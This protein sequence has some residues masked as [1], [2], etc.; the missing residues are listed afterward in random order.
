MELLQ[1]S[2]GDA[3][4]GITLEKIYQEHRRLVLKIC[5]GI[6]HDKESAEDAFQ[7]PFLKVA[8]N[9]QELNKNPELIRAKNNLNSKKHCL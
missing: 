1:N 7:S 9:I 6:L 3:S 2:P 8:Q 5:I 4:T